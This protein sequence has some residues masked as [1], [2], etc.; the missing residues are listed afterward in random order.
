[1]VK[2]TVCECNRSRGTNLTNEFN[3][4]A[5]APY[6]TSRPR[7]GQGSEVRVGAHAR[8]RQVSTIRGVGGSR[9]DVY[10]MPGRFGV[11]SSDP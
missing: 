1:M 5:T 10:V 7:L 6:H 2:G 8:K 3:A 9:V 11:R 4:R